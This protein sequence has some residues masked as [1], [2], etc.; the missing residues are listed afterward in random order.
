MIKRTI[1]SPDRVSEKSN[2]GSLDLSHLSFERQLVWQ[3]ELTEGTLKRA[4]KQD[5][6]VL[7]TL[8]DNNPFNYRNKVVFHVLEDEFLQLG[9][10]TTEPVKLVKVDNFILANK[11]VNEILTKINKAKIKVDPFKLK[12]VVFKNNSQ[13]QLVVTLVS[14]NKN[15]LGK[16]ELISLLE[17]FK[18]VIGITINIKP[19][20]KVI[21]GHKSYEVSG[22][23]ELKEDELYIT[24]KS[25][26]QVNL[27]VMKMT[28]DVISK[29]I[30]G[31][32]I[33]D[34]YCGV[35]SIGFYLYKKNPNLTI[36]MIDNQV[37]NILLANKTKRENDYKSVNIIKDNS[38]D[39]VEGLSADTLVLDPPR[40]GLM[41]KLV[42]TILD[43]KFKE[44]IY[45]S[46]DLKTLTRDLRLL[47]ST[48]EIKTIQPIKMFPQTTSLE[49]LV[50]LKL[51]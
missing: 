47:T 25:F 28:Y 40:Q 41:P 15:F 42:D 39:A 3:K 50:V 29:N 11:I 16:D 20:D 38:E 17:T 43:K 35:G 30:T 23:S 5:V 32:K 22:T 45:L 9:L 33:I 37:D 7:D 49:T 48:Y 26:L 44:I 19:N 4:L 10:Y 2:L 1:D 24:D 46:C 12:H 18:Q 6:K 13:N 31:K 36:D 14:T 27:P 8:T 21:L 51:K 34:A